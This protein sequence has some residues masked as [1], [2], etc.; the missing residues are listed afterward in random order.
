M[1]PLKHSKNLAARMGRWS[2]SHWKTAVFGWLAF[3]VAVRLRRRC[4]V[5]TKQIDQ[6]DANVGES[7]T[8]D[9]IIDDAGFTVDKNGESIEEQSRDGARPV[10]DADGRRLR[11]SGPR[12]RTSRRR[13]RRFPQVT[14]L[15]S[16]LG[17]GPR[18]PRSRRTATRRWS[19]S[20][21]KGT[22]EEAV[23]YI[24]D[25]TAAIDK[26]EARHPGFYVESAGVSTEK[27]L[28]KEIQGGL[29][30]AGLISIPLTIII[31][32]IVL[33]SLVGALDP[34]AARAH[35]GRG[36]DAA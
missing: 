1:T 6:N 18:R 12:S 11:R 16:P 35:V 5:G 17:A 4:S 14:K 13:S 32:L 34:A 31:L 36:R 20:S 29:A 26:V 3:V 22:Y 33:G 2:A 27:A 8:A 30:K 19:S 23:L 7:R 25:I 24:D 28:D 15:Q 10:E 9:R 21:P